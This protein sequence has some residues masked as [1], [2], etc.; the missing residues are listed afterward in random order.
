MLSE[1]RNEKTALTRRTSMPRDIRPPLQPLPDFSSLF[2]NGTSDIGLVIAIIA[3]RRIT[4]VVL[5]PGGSI[6]AF[7]VL[8]GV[9]FGFQ[10][11]ALFLRG[12]FVVAGHGKGVAVDVEVWFRGPWDVCAVLGIFPRLGLR[13][14]WVEEAWEVAGGADG[15]FRCGVEGLQ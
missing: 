13:E 4:V 5:A 11:L 7:P 9:M 8:G 14:R 1:S 12:W 3:R 15:E 10:A 6:S 2:I